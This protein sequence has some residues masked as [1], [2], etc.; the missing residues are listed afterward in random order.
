MPLGKI[1]RSHSMTIKFLKILSK[2]QKMFSIPFTT[3]LSVNDSH[4]QISIKT[5]LNLYA[6]T[7][8]NKLTHLF[9]WEIKIY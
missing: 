7:I 3:K 1:S 8:T 4:I 5:T 2:K 9:L 6:F